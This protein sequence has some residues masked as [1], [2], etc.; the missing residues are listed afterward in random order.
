[1]TYK[2][3]LETPVD[4][5]K[6]INYYDNKHDTVLL[7]LM[8]V[9]TLLYVLTGYF[10]LLS[11]FLGAALGIFASQNFKHLGSAP[12][13]YFRNWWYAPLWKIRFET[14]SYAL[15][16]KAEMLVFCDKTFH[17]NWYYNE[18]T[19][20]LRKRKQLIALKLAFPEIVDYEL[21]KAGFK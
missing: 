14:A 3:R 4:A 13:K 6:A 10:L 7:P 18:E 1:M 20:F 2:G 12:R 8:Y 19:L 11:P 9:F 17:N 21:T 15:I 16:P 5:F